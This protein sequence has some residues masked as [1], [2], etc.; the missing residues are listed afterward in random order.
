MPP[1]RTYQA[2]EALPATARQ[3]SLGLQQKPSHKRKRDSPEHHGNSRP[4]TANGLQG[5]SGDSGDQLDNILLGENPDFTNLAQHLQQHA[6][7]S[8]N[9]SAAAEALRQ[10]MPSLT[11][12]QPTELS[13]QSTNTVDDEDHGES[14]FNIG[15]DGNQNHH[16]EGTPYNLDAYTGEPS[17]NQSGVGGSKPAVG[18]DEWHKVRKDNH[19]E[20]KRALIYR[21]LQDV[22]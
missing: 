20:G 21:T 16:T 14:S 6:A 7:N 5:N 9:S 22:N 3:T 19:K 2:N 13:F 4:K 1:T 11:V 17:R 18:T 15:V 12:P 10:H 8:L